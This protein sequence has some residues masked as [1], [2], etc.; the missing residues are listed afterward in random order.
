MKWIAALLIAIGVASPAMAESCTKS[1]E[2][3]LEGLGGSLISPPA[4]YQDL[5]KVC[6][7][8]LIL[9]NVKDA[10]VLKDSGIAIVPKRDSL[11]AT[12]ETL[13]QFCQRF[14]KNTAR[15]V[16]PREQRSRPTVG[17]I[18]SLSSTGSASCKKI[19]GVT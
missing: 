5:F 4:R 10:Y 1:R 17:L 3:I 14:P 7:E 18:I 19:R 13:A 11:T 15:F 6:V 16:T 2:Y 8:A 12:A 9:S